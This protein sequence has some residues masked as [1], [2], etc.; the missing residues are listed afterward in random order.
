M[1]HFAEID[2][3]NMVL[4]VLVVDNAQ[5]YRGQDF[6]SIDIGLGGRWIQTSYNGTTRKNFAGG[7]YYYDEVRDAFIPPKP[8]PSWILNDATCQWEAPVTRPTGLCH[9]DETSLAWVEGV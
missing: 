2:A 9:W 8:F 7:G 5:E 3:N 1:A 6:L 4:R